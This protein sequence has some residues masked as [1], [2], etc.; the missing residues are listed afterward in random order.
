MRCFFPCIDSEPVTAVIHMSVCLYNLLKSLFWWNNSFGVG[1]SFRNN[2]SD[3]LLWAACLSVFSR[4][5]HVCVCVCLYDKTGWL[6]PEMVFWQVEYLSVKNF[7]FRSDFILISTINIYVKKIETTLF[8][9]GY[10][11]ECPIH[12]C[13]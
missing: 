7:R 10:S 8:S 2:I 13:L 3:P 9:E 12:L 1:Q 4:S 6:E 11:N 5:P